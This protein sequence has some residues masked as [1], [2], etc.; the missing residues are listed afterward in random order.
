MIGYSSNREFYSPKYSPETINSEMPDH[1]IVLYWNPN[2]FAEKGLATV[3][4]FT[5]H[6]IA[7]YRVYVEGI[8]RD[9]KVCLG[10]SG[11]DVDNSTSQR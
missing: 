11:F 5:S 4:F 2:I 7:R 8:T 6:D 10:S 9:G 1:R 3:D